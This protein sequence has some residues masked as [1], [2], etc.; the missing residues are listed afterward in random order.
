MIIFNP[1][2]G[3]RRRR[4]FEAVLT[5]LRAYGCTIS[6]RETGGSGDAERLA[7]AA[8]SNDHDLLV[9][10]GGDGTIN[11]AINGLDGA[12]I[13]ITILP[14]G[15][16]NALAAEIGQKIDPEA[17]AR[18][19]AT[20][21]PQPISLGSANGRRFLLMAGVGLD[22]RIVQSVSLPLKRWIGKG[23]YA[24]AF[25]R[26][27]LRFGFPRYDVAIDGAHYHP[28]SVIVANARSYAGRYV[29]APD[30]D[31]RSPTFQVCLFERPGR[32]WAMAYG[33]ALL[34]GFLP[35]LGGY[36]IVSG[37][38]IEISGPPAD[39]VQGDGDIIAQLD[40]LI[41]VLPNALKLVYPADTDSKRLP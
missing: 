6:V 27:W 29:C 13:P 22:A 21:T 41:E 10:A 39:P 14:L 15:T 36:R 23:A 4:L 8:A 31:L 30:A 7:A 16:A 26:Q 1:A 9:V 18:T 12:A 38:R 28:A 34:A 25:L 20:G 11:E 40:V 3:G 24:L 5:R 17:I 33:A 35:K 2:A 37:Q 32:L 19:I